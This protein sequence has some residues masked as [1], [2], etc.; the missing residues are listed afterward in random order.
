VGIEVKPTT[1]PGV[2]SARHLR[3][4]RE[5]LGE[6]FAAGVVLHLGQ[7]ASSFGDRIQAVPVS[8]LWGDRHPASL[9]IR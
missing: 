6:R 1:S 4:L 3:W 9:R 7:R 5:R 2:D 8:A